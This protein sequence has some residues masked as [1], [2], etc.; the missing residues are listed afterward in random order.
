MPRRLRIQFEG[1]IYHVMSRGNALV[2]FDAIEVVRQFDPSKPVGKS[3]NRF[4]VT[5]GVQ[6]ESATLDFSFVFSIGATRTRTA[7]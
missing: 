7:T 2:D 3:R 6:G 1:A 4:V 5:K